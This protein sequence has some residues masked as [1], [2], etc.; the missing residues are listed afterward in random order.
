VTLLKSYVKAAPEMILGKRYEG[1]EVDMWSLGVILF[2]LLCGHLPFDDEN[3]KELYKKIS[4]G[5]YTI[6]EYVPPPCK[7]LIQRMITV[8]PRK[9]ATLEEVKHHS[10]VVEGFDG[11]PENYLPKRAVIDPDNL[12]HNIVQ[13]MQAFGFKTEDV[14]VAFKEYADQDSQLRE[15]AEGKKIKFKV[16]PVVTT[17]FL[18][19]EML[20]REETKLQA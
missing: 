6:P 17:Y 3:M 9:R 14:I 10:W 18:L 7:Q 20:K 16:N 1:P 2:A 19:S 5:T 4:H 12:D 11:P 13:R 8:D 15:N